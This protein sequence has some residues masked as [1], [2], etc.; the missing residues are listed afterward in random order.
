MSVIASRFGIT[1]VA[2]VA[3]G[4]VLLSAGPAVAGREIGS[5]SQGTGG[6]THTSGDA[7]GDGTI[8]AAVVF[9]RSKNG[10]GSRA[11]AVTPVGNWS[12][13]ACWYAPKYSPAQLQKHLEP[14]WEAGSTGYGWDADQRDRYVKGHPYKDFNKDKAGDGY[15]WDSYVNKSYPPGWDSCNKPYFWVDKGDPPPADAPEAVTPEILA[16]LAYAEIRVPDTDVEMSPT[17]NQTVNLPT[18]AWLDKAQFKPVS[19]T[20]SVP[21]LDI[22]ATTTATPVSLKLEPGTADAELHPA[23]GECPINKDGSIGTPYTKGSGDRTPPCGLTYLRASGSDG[24]YEFKATV[25][26]KINWEG[27]GG[28]GGELPDGTFGTTQDVTVQEV[29]SINR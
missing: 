10:S 11:G 20:A 25:T 23:S 18:W 4:M 3:A 9:D 1:T 7:K 24:S 27:S 28:A 6:D 12:P 29:Q 14:I 19:V 16:G 8:S 15:W 17:Q 2:A 5:G 26:W 13:P 22:E 21:V